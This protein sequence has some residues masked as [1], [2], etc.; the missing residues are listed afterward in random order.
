MEV[1]AKKVYCISGKDLLEFWTGNSNVTSFEP[2]VTSYPIRL[3][4]SDFNHRMQCLEDSIIKQ[5]LEEKNCFLV[6]CNCSQREVNSLI[7][8]NQTDT[9]NCCE[10]NKTFCEKSSGSD[11]C[12]TDDA[13]SG[14]KCHCASCDRGIQDGLPSSCNTEKT[15]VDTVNDKLCIEHKEENSS[16][17]PVVLN[18][19]SNKCYSQGPL[20]SET[21]PKNT[22]CKQC[23]FRQLQGFD[24]NPPSFDN[25]LNIL[26]LER[27]SSNF[28][29][30]LEEATRRRVFNL[31]RERTRFDRAITSHDEEACQS[32]LEG[33]TAKVG[34]LFSGGID[35]MVLAAMADRYGFCIVKCFP[36]RK[37]CVQICYHIE[38]A[39]CWS[40][41]GRQLAVSSC[42]WNGLTVFGHRNDGF[43]V[44]LFLNGFQISSQNIIREV[45]LS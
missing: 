42:F 8:S 45:T 30:I 17:E 20:I 6:E 7:K 29:E 4:T 16:K 43:T 23:F 21:M 34:L 22:F 13:K 15:V 9:L 26:L 28:M 39:K 14:I 12:G 41:R 40:R 25:R 37:I 38:M 24:E 35:S 32:S 5:T 27:Y 33:K 18:S 2:C 31:P 44:P 3:P 19:E 36:C 10:S 1:P 11:C